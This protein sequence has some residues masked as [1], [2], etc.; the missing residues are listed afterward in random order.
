M[1]IIFLDQR[2]VNQKTCLKWY[3][4]KLLKLLL[5]Y[6]YDAGNTI[7]NMGIWKCGHKVTE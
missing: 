6:L 4:L 1:C 7:I 5:E 3:F 2:A